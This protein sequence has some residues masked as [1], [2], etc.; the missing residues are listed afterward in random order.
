MNP[1]PS[2]I[3]AFVNDSAAQPEVDGAPTPPSDHDRPGEPRTRRGHRVKLTRLECVVAFAVLVVWLLLFGGGILVDSEPYRSQI[4]AEGV[5]ALKA[6]G[7]RGQEAAQ[8]GVSDVP[9][10]N[11]PHPPVSAAAAGRPSER[12]SRLLAAWAVVLTCFLPLNLAWLCVAASALGAFGNAANLSDDDSDERLS[13]TSNPYVSALL[14]GFFVYLFMMSGLL[15]LDDAPFS[16]AGPGQYIRLAGFLS[17]FSFVVSYQPRL[18]SAL[19]LSAFQRIQVR[20][21]DA[22]GASTQ[23]AATTQTGVEQVRQTTTVQTVDIGRE[24]H[25]R[26][27]RVGADDRQ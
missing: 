19:I 13:D 22:S 23:T 26:A 7:R 12:A 16:N 20:G 17:L 1:A 21:G 4:S 6:E 24:V 18:F 11:A 3:R 25:T 9:V 10:A 8:S 27:E 5:E 14:R 15:V 2:P